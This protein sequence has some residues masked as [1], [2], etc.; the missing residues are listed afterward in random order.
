MHCCNHIA[1]NEF[2]IFILHLEIGRGMLGIGNERLE[3]LNKFFNIL[4]VANDEF[5]QNSIVIK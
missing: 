2:L 1:F 3:R 4:H 5:I